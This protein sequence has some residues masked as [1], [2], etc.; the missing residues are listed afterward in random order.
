M[1]LDVFLH[2]VCVLPSRTLAKEACDRGKVILNGE[3]AKA[4]REIGTGDVIRLDLGVRVLELEVT[5]V[6]GGQVSRKGAHEF[7]RV[8][9]EKRLDPW[10]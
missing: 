6:P 2:K 5:G 1:R 10:S 9:A 3:P 8:L 7:Y 4:S